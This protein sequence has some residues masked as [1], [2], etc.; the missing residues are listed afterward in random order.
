M[1]KE[2]DVEHLDEAYKFFK[3]SRKT[4]ESIIQ[5]DRVHIRIFDIVRLSKNRMSFHDISKYISDI[6]DAKTKREEIIEL[7]QDYAYYKGFVPEIS[8][9]KVKYF[10]LKEPE[11]TTLDKVM[12]SID[13]HDY[14]RKKIEAKM[15]VCFSQLELSF[16]GEKQSIESLI[17]SKKVPSFSTCMFEPTEISIRNSLIDGTGHRKADKY[18]EGYNMIGFDIDDG[19]T[20]DE[21]FEALN[22]Y[23]Y[24]I[25][26]TK[27]HRKEK[28]GILN[29]DRFRIL[30][31][32]K[33][34]IYVDAE[35]H[36]QLYI[37]LAEFLGIKV[38]DQATKNVSRLFFTN[39]DGEVYKNEAELI[40]VIGLVP[41]TER[42]ESLLPLLNNMA[43]DE[44][45]DDIN[46][47]ERRRIGFVKW[48][49]VNTSIGNRNDNL[50]K[51]KRFFIELG[52]NIEY[53]LNALNNMMI[54]PL[55]QK[56]VDDL[57]KRR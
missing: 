33:T 46:D 49:L 39:P 44:Y 20:L 17:V 41:N 3:Q 55:P 22:Q 43:H 52:L 16:F 31:P 57:I 6:P 21:A 10:L 42:A 9:N 4:I 32:L 11:K 37:N 38:F 15:S 28:D 56:D 40:D 45:G 24:L 25:Y 1:T 36:K 50:Y 27:S 30:I 54:D 14:D 5:P 29:G 19:W 8:G 12:V 51:A 13:T 7:F 26:T 48:F 23:T 53:E 34:K 47:I 35:R 18:I 2:V